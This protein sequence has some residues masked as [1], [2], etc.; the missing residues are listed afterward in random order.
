MNPTLVTSSVFTYKAA[1]DPQLV[2]PGIDPQLF[3]TTSFFLR[4]CNTQ[5]GVMYFLRAATDL[6]VDAELTWS[7]F[8]YTDITSPSPKD[9]K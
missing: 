2:E 5:T 4:F 9:T 6:T 8:N 1:R 3:D 7:A